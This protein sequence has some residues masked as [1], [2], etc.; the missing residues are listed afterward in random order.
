MTTINKKLSDF[1][2]N[3]CDTIER[4][5]KEDT[6]KVCPK[7]EKNPNFKLP[8]LWFDLSDPYLNEKFCEYH[9]RVYTA[10]AVKDKLIMTTEVVELKDITPSDII[11]TAIN[12]F[13]KHFKKRPSNDNREIAKKNTKIIKN[14]SIPRFSALQADENLG[15]VHLV[16]IP[17]MSFNALENLPEEEKE[18]NQSSNKDVKQI[19]IKVNGFL[20]KHIQIMGALRIYGAVY[21]SLSGNEN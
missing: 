12:K 20:Q 7:C 5:K 2:N 16:V 21:A 4:V 13:I 1:Q 18:E 17:A 19:K 8:K 10:D 11:D 9:V 3:E 15:R 14:L 6:Q